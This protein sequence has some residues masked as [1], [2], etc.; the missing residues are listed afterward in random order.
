MTFPIN[1]NISV[2]ANIHLNKK[3]VSGFS[4][5]WT[6]TLLHSTQFDI[7]LTVHQS[8][9]FTNYQINAQFLYSITIC[10]LHYN[11]RQVS[12]INMS[13][14]RRTN[15]VITACGIVTLC[16]R[17]YSMPDESRLFVFLKMGMLMLETFRGL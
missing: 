5:K 12:S 16:K 10:T 13:I 7:F 15:C 14:V 17:L 4:A 2:I 6:S 8:T 1:M 9:D 11:H 3:H